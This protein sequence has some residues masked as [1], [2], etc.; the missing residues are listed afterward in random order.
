MLNEFPKKLILTYAGTVAYLVPLESLKKGSNRKI[1]PDIRE[2]EYNYESENPICAA[3]N[4][5]GKRFSTTL[6]H[7]NYLIECK[8]AEVE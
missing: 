1:D 6:K 3:C 2:Y 4:K 8:L 7:I 5:T